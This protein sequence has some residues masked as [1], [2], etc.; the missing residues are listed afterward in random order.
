MHLQT[1]ALDP[2][3]NV[4][5]PVAEVANTAPTPQADATIVDLLGRWLDLS[6]LERR[7]FV[8]LAREL[9]VSSNLVESSTLDLSERF[10]SLATG[11][12]A[13]MHK[14]D[15]IIAVAK[16]IEVDGKSMPLDTAMQAVEGVLVKVIETI[17]SISKH[18]MRMVYALEDVALQVAG[19]EQCV[20][21][22]EAIN[23]QTRYV[24]LNAAIEANRSGNEGSAFRVIAREIKE[25]SQKTEVTSKQVRERIS[26]V[27]RGVKH[28]HGVLQEIATLDMS[29]HILAKQRLDAMITGVI[30]QNRAFNAVLSDT[31]ESSAEMART[32][33]QLITGVQFQDRTKQHLG[34]V[35]DALDVLREGAMQLQ[36][37]TSEAIPGAFNPGSIDKDL[38][39]RL[40]DKQ[41]LGAVKERI[42]ARLLSDEHAVED[43]GGSNPQGDDIEL[44]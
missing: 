21:Q 25:L 24:A 3:V 5:G 26:S 28:G 43:E 22:I 35:I 33:G 36:Q 37:A 4:S 14:V 29:E 17:L 19:A 10:Q 31:A 15:E 6:E 16:S 1:A 9:T 12:Q 34:H 39:Q 7:T 42:L 11:A 30:Q 8:A 18:A 38:L 41:T 2:D 23:T 32:I 44:F 13:Q 27:T 40:V 20:A